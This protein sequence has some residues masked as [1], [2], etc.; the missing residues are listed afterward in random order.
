MN[1]SEMFSAFSYCLF[2]PS[3]P[4]VHPVITAVRIFAIA[5]VPLKLPLIA[6]PAAIS[7][8]KITA[9]RNPSFKPPRR[10]ILP[11]INPAAIQPQPKA[12]SEKYSAK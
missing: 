12:I 10:F 6:A 3:T 4:P 2:T 1:G 9:Q 11:Q 5:A 8:R 7:T